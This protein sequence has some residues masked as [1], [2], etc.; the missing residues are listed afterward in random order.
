MERVI[1]SKLKA[2]ATLTGLVGDRVYAA[3]APQG[4]LS[5]GKYVTYRLI[6]GGP[7]NSMS[8]ASDSF[9]N[10]MQIDCWGKSKTES[11]GV[12]DAVAGVLSGL[13]DLTTTPKINMVH[14]LSERDTVTGPQDGTGAG[15]HRITQDYHIEHHS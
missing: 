13:R 6:S 5:L 9:V 3:N 2:D 7:L 15:V 11:Q 4:S 14:F 1:V 8:G 10:R 12:A